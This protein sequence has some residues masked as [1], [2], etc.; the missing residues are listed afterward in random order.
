MTGSF[1]S[2]TVV[3]SR[4]RLDV[5]LPVD[6]PVGE[7]TGELATMLDEP[8]G[9]PPPRWGLVRLGGEVMD[10]EQGL[11]AQ[12]VP[13]GAMLFLRDVGAALRPVVV[14]D[15][16]TAIAGA[17]EASPWRWTPL[18]LQRLFVGAG[19]AFVVGA[20]ALAAQWLAAGDTAA[21]P[22]VL[23]AAAIV[24][25]AGAG[26]GRLGRARSSGVALAL[27]A[28]PLWAVA[29][30]GLAEGGGLEGPDAVAAGLVAVSF[31]GLAAG[32]AAPGGAALAAGL[33]V[34]SL[35]WALTLGVLT[36]LAGSVAAGAAALVPL[37]VTG[38]RLLPWIVVRMARLDGEPPVRAL[39]ERTATARRL[40]GFLTAG[41]AVTLGGACVVLAMDPTWWGRGLAAA[42]ALAAVL[43]ARRRRF[44]L[45]V[46]PLM[47]VALV[48]VVV[49]ELG[50]LMG[51]LPE[52]E[53]LALPL[54]TAAALAGMG[55]AGRGVRLPV[56]VRRQLEWLEALTATATAVLALGML[57][58][59]DEAA[60][61]AGRFT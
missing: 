19:T 49:F 31:G 11:G 51:T 26:I 40:L 61:F 23:A 45:E 2:I 28:L 50:L 20:G 15:Y 9:G 17:V 8:A 46:A 29:G 18:G 6:V 43:H 38:L 52:W 37:A 53:R 16:A 25:A 60:R 5:S 58:L 27:A 55:L 42:A 13:P 57:G 33:V 39:P 22:G 56:G 59:Y 30:V 7:L 3:G 36:G 44:V 1:F 48:T 54:A 14:D 21:A 47:L 41:M 35:P 34:A 24:T 4:R 32:L 12:H 10:A